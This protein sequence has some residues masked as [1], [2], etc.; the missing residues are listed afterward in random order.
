MVDYKRYRRVLVIVIDSIGVGGAPDAASFSSE[1]AD[2]LGHIAEYFTNEL[3]E[4]LAIPNL[5]SLGVSLTHPGGLAGVPAP[6]EPRGCYGRMRVTSYGND[7]LDGHWEM[8]CLPAR[9]HVDYFPE[10]FPASL[11]SKI[12]GFCGRR[13]IVNKPYSGTQVIAEYGERQLKTGELI[14]YTSADSVLQI[15]AHEEVIP[16]DEL[17]SICSFTRGIVNG[18]EVTLGRVIARP[19]VGTCADDF[20][21]TANRRDYGLEPTGRTALDVLR[22]AG[23]D[24]IGVGKISDLF[25][26][27]G[28]TRSFHNESNSDGM[29]HVAA[30]LGEDWSG[31]CFTNLVDFDARYGH[32]RDAEGDGRALEEFDRGLGVAMGL[33]HD[34]D[35][36][37]VTADHGNDPTYVGTDHTREL[38]PLLAWSPSMRGGADLGLRATCSDL[39]ET[40]LDNFG[41]PSPGGEGTSFLAEVS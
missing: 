21:R 5:A 6:A 9:F 29:D 19:F 16:L 24:V 41:L 7:S 15:A 14:V 27:N 38:V 17:Y 18:P 25:C 31:L 39:G 10:G 23:A 11:L 28:L 30:V 33:M 3:G 13:C 1:G 2:T 8:M 34:D 12:E 4:P 35:L 20:S 40:I 26:G 36:L 37:V 22:D 32:R